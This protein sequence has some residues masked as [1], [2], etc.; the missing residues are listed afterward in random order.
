MQYNFENYSFSKRIKSMLRVDCKRLSCS[1]LFYILLAVSFVIPILI[2]VMTSMMDGSVSVNPQTGEETIMEGF[3]NLWQ[4]IGSL[5]TDS[6]NASAGA[7]MEITSMCNINLMYFAVAVLVTIFTCDDFRSGYAKNLFTVRA[8]KTDYV[9]SKTIVLFVAS[10][11]MIILFFIGSCVGG[12]I[13]GVP[14][15][16]LGFN[17]GNLVACI[18]AKAFLVG[19]FVPIYLLMSVI[20][21]QKIW[22]AMLLSFGVGMLF[23]N[24]APMITPLDSNALNV[25]LSLIGSALLSLGLGYVSNLI[26]KKTALI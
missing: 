24:V 26:L 16:M 14:M 21:K 4:I 17:V 19:M 9:I 5:S 20:A 7:Q 12:A 3:K 15:D 22:L 11:C 23:F 25:I 6:G 18:L 8:K 10:A 13:A 1:S 2:L